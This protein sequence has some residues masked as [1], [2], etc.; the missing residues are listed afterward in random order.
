MACVTGSDAQLP[1]QIV[2][3]STLSLSI[4]N[5]GF[6]MLQVV[7]LT[8]SVQ[9]ITSFNYTFNFKGGTFNGFIDSDIQS[10]LE[11]TEYFQHAISAKGMVC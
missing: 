7:I 10:V 2:D 11:G 9:P 1:E 5:Q 4:D 8:K 3:T 6:A